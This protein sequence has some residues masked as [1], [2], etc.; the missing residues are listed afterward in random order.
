[1]NHTYFLNKEMMS[2]LQNSF[3]I[4]VF[5]SMVN[6]VC[7]SQS[8]RSLYPKNYECVEI[9]NETSMKVENQKTTEIMEKFNNA[10]VHHDPAL[11]ADLIGENCVMESIQGP[12]GIR[13]EGYAAC[14]KFWEELAVDP[15]TQ[16]DLEEIFVAG[17]R[18]TIRW[19]YRWGEGLTSSV[20]GVNLMRVQSGKIVEAL[21]YAKTAPATGLDN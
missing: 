19:R 20:R 1:L 4:V 9:K 6:Q 16:F 12:D 18:A 13:Y 8:T 17:E 14:L 7:L 21:G 3:L 11:L 15:N 10:F 5:M 2:P